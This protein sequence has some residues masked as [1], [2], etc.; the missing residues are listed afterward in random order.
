MRKIFVPG[1]EVDIDQ[2]QIKTALLNEHKD[3]EGKWPDDDFHGKSYLLQDARADNR[4]EASGGGGDEEMQVKEQ[5][6]LLLL[7][8]QCPRC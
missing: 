4:I 1:R 7:V 6:F 8:D 2:D 3:G 5:L